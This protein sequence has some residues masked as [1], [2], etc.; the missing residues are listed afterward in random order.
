M[1][2]TVGLNTSP[3]KARLSTLVLRLFNTVPH[4]V[5]IIKLFHSYFVT[6]FANVMNHN[7]NI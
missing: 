4:V 7:I 6:N 2:V 5:V 3:S 1:K